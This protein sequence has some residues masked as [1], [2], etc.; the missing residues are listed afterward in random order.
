[1]LGWMLKGKGKFHTFTLY[2]NGT[3]KSPKACVVLLYLKEALPVV[4]LLEAA[5][6]PEWVKS[7]EDYQEINYPILWGGHLVRPTRKVGC[8]FI[9]GLTHR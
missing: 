4:K 9:S 1:M 6:F 3:K 8:F 2:P 5:A 7:L